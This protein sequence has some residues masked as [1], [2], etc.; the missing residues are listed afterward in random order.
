MCV[1]VCVCVCVCFHCSFWLVHSDVFT[2][3]LKAIVCMWRAVYIALY[4]V[5]N[6]HFTNPPLNPPTT[7]HIYF[8][9]RVLETKIPSTLFNHVWFFVMKF[10]NP[11]K[12]P[13]ALRS[14]GFKIIIIIIIIISDNFHSFP[15]FSNSPYFCETW[16]SLLCN[17]VCQV[18]TLVGN[19]PHIWIPST[20]WPGWSIGTHPPTLVLGTLT[21][22]FFFFLNSEVS[23]RPC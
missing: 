16:F 14:L 13:C 17:K 12:Y 23:S 15:S 4:K 3:G 6:N 19:G 7:H 10:L 18:F 9:R 8:T 22:S 1:C 11:R 2:S 5:W 20:P 21:F